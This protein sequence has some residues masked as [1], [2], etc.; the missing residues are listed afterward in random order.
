VINTVASTFSEVSNGY[1]AT[2]SRIE[3][4]PRFLRDYAELQRTGPQKLKTHP[5]G[6]VLAYWLPLTIYQRLPGVEAAMVRLIRAWAGDTNDVY[7]AIQQY[8]NVANQHL[9]DYL[10]GAA[11]FCSLWLALAGALAVLPAY[12]LGAAGGDRR[13]GVLAAILLALMP[14]S[15]FYW[16]SLD[17]LL[18]T[19]L[20][21]A[22][23]GVVY[24]LPGD[25]LRAWPALGAGVGLGLTL[26][27]SLG[28]LA[29]CGLSGV[30]ALLAAARG[31]ARWRH[32]VGA[33]VLVASGVALVTAAVTLAG[34]DTAAVLYQGLT[35]HRHGGAGVQYRPYAPWVVFNVVDYVLL[36]G[37]P[38]TVVALGGLGRD[39]AEPVRSIG[40]AALAT[41]LLLDLSGV[42]RAETERLWIFLNP[43]LAATAAAA[44]VARAERFWTLAI[45]P[46]QLLLMALALPPLVRPC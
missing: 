10:M 38:L 22:L 33:L 32:A 29:A 40:L 13:A 20:A 23:A 7:L 28:A 35:A 19:L 15:L 6:A 4:V 18:V 44:A 12:W 42:T 46:L 37:L 27:V 9:P 5:P 39:C 2:A 25:R 43:A 24:A 11:L 14:N 21:A 30:Y 26:F 34:V 17:T 45:Q 3:R 8:P 1:F 41:L 36:A 16:L 31:R